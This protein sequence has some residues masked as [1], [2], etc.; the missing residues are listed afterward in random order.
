MAYALVG[1]VI[2]DTMTTASDVREEARRFVPW[3]IAMPLIAAGSFLL[4]GVFIGATRTRDMAVMMG[5]SFA[6][7]LV[8]VALFWPLGN[9]GLWAAIVCLFLARFATLLWRYP[10]LERSV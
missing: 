7:Y 3:L 9:A 10:A 4:D 1:G 2:I 5:W 8:A 6:A